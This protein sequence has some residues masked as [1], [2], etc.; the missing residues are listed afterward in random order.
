M[1]GSRFAVGDLA[2]R[3]QAADG[4]D[5]F[6]GTSGVGLGSSTG[7]PSGGHWE[8]GYGYHGCLA[9]P[10]ECVP[11]EGGVMGRSGRSAHPFP[12]ALH[13]RRLQSSSMVW[14]PGDL[15]AVPL[16]RNIKEV[17]K[18][19]RWYRGGARGYKKKQSAAHM[20]KTQNCRKKSINA[21]LSCCYMSWLWLVLWLVLCPAGGLQRKTQLSL[22]IF[23]PPAPSPESA[24]KHCP[25]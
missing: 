4:N 7:N 15:P 8:G 6:S 12:T 13:V 10:L 14:R 5:P 21:T 2:G 9:V 17:G 11:V 25:S 24:L 19:P 20:E 18:K 22:A 16:A 3:G 1:G 23:R